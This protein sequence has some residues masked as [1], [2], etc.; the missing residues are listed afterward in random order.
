MKVIRRIFPISICLYDH[1]GTWYLI[2]SNLEQARWR[3]GRPSRYAIM[4]QFRKP[5][6]RGPIRLPKQV[7]LPSRQQ[8]KQISDE[9]YRNPGSTVELTFGQSPESLSLTAVKD[10]AHGEALLWMLYRGEGS[11]SALEWSHVT[12]DYERIYNLIC[13]QF[14]GWD[15]KPKTLTEIDTVP[16]NRTQDFETQSTSNRYEALPNRST[17]E[18]DLRNMQVP[19]LLQS[20]SL[21]KQTGRLEVHS[22]TDT[23]VVFFAE[24]VA[25]H[26]A[27]RNSF[28]DKALV[29]MMSWEEGQF[30]F[31][32]GIKTDQNTVK[33]RLESL[34][35]EGVSFADQN[36]FLTQKG[37]ALTAYP[38]RTRPQITEAEFD[39]VLKEQ[40]TGFDIKLV[41]EIY[42]M[43]DEKS[44]VIDLLR[45]TSMTKVEWVPVFYNLFTCSLVT[46]SAS[47]TRGDE[48]PQNLLINSATIDWSQV[49]S[50]ERMLSRP[51]TTLL[52]YSSFLYLLRHEYMRFYRYQRPFAI[53]IIE[54]GQKSLRMGQDAPT[55]EPLSIRGVRTLA[56]TIKHATRPTDIFGHFEIIDFALLLP[57]TDRQSAHG[58]VGR[59]AELCA[60]ANIIEDPNMALHFEIGV[61]AMPDDTTDIDR[62]MVMAKPKKSEKVGS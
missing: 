3:C 35:M 39:K 56:E 21:G 16:L 36:N 43:I 28:G 58:M 45:R 30:C 59:L 11:A 14:P 42:T 51:D 18:G 2:E 1:C 49:Q 23:A 7:G 53:A 34:M 6:N 26:C 9:A 24:G 62:L 4:M 54:V 60:Q 19:N 40:G 31:F 8:V 41:K 32:P 10:R 12:P 27:L 50:V 33:R 17:L 44:T 57:E 15:L 55:R 20:I 47:S 46:F 13:T 25:C 29:E 61:A 48:S 38:Q 37:L 22:P 52:S 5:E